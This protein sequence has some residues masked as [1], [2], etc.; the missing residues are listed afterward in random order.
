M[1]QNKFQIAAT[2]ARGAFTSEEW[3][4]LTFSEQADSIYRQLRL[5][6]MIAQ[7][8]EVVPAPL[9]AVAASRVTAVVVDVGSGRPVR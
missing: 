5:M 9:A 4:S 3:A 7:E 1:P 6:E 2:R 8:S